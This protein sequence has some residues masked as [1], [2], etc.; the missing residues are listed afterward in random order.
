M[1]LYFVPSNGRRV[2]C[3][4]VSNFTPDHHCFYPIIRSKP[5]GL[6]VL[7]YFCKAA[8]LLNLIPVSGFQHIV[9]SSW[10]SAHFGAGVLPFG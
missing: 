5:S 3:R 7:E 9:K 1:V 2:S 10:K 8:E 4:S 6:T